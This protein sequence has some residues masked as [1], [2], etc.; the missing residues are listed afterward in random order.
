M[1]ECKA[2]D[3]K[4]IIK[5][6]DEFLNHPIKFSKAFDYLQNN[7][8]DECIVLN[9]EGCFTSKSFSW[10]TFPIGLLAHTE[11]CLGIFYVDFIESENNKY[12]IMKIPYVDRDK[13][14]NAINKLENVINTFEL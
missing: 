7:G 8:Y 1:N 3:G 6:R 5:Y 9:D 4:Y 14:N 12:N 11:A 13:L 2:V 10:K